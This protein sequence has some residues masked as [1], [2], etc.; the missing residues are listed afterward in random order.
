VHSNVEKLDPYLKFNGILRLQ[1]LCHVWQIINNLVS[2][3][4]KEQM[5]KSK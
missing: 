1:I 4:C 5:Y 3:Q 2:L